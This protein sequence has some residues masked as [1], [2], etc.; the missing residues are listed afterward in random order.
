MQDHSATTKL[1]K[2]Q[3]LPKERQGHCVLVH[4]E[5]G[6]R[7]EGPCWTGQVMCAGLTYPESLAHHDCPALQ[8][9][10][11]HGSQQHRYLL[12]P[13]HTPPAPVII[14]HVHTMGRKGPGARG[15]KR[16]I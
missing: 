15:Q 2:Q 9:P 5:R 10:H 7:R 8:Q 3:A 12:G 14:S 4:L 6:G 11:S 16:Q 1:N 13:G